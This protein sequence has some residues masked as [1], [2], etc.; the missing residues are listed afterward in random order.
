MQAISTIAIV[1]SPLPIDKI[2][3]V[4]AWL[5]SVLWDSTLPLAES[6]SERYPTDFDIHRLK[7][8]LALED[9]S[10]KIIQA[11]RDVFEIRDAD[12]APDKG[13]DGSSTPQCKV[14]LIGRGLGEDVQPWQRSFEE[15]MARDE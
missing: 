12:P 2:P 7:G 13:S 3:R 14:V 11:V 9:G 4:D 6:V 10:S 5:R 8:I 1:T 15:F